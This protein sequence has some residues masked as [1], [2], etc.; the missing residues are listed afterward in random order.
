MD[1]AYNKIVDY[2]R[3]LRSRTNPEIETINKKKC[4]FYLLDLEMQGVST[5]N[6]YYL[7]SESISPL[8]EKYKSLKSTYEA[9]AMEKGSEDAILKDSKSYYWSMYSDANKAIA[10]LKKALNKYGIIHGSAHD[11]TIQGVSSNNQNDDYNDSNDGVNHVTTNNS[12]ITTHGVSETED[13]L[14][15]TSGKVAYHRLWNELLLY[16]EASTRGISK[17]TLGEFTSVEE[18]SLYYSDMLIKHGG[19]SGYRWKANKYY[20]RKTSEGRAIAMNIRE[21][22][23][24]K[25]KANGAIYEE[26]IKMYM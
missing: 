20:Q 15:V 7:I 2:Y 11:N 24:Q 13:Y 18:M 4:I 12:Q 19:Y 23:D 1:R 16:L 9:I 26:L 8:D 21:E 5:S 25:G 17:V 14:T 10:I 22:A 6:L 3:P